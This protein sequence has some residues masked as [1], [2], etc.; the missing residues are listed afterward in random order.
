MRLRR[1]RNF[2][3]HKAS[4]SA[5]GSVSPRIALKP[6]SVGTIFI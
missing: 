6:I 3:V 5:V 1:A 4:T 2:Q